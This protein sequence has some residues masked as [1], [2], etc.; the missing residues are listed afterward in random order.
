[1][2]LNSIPNDVFL[3]RRVAAGDEDAFSKLFDDYQ[4]QVSGFVFSIIGDKELTQEIVQDI[5]I[6]V[7]QK[8]EELL[9]I[10]KFDAYLF[11]LSKNYTLNCIRKIQREQQKAT[12]YNTLFPNTGEE[13]SEIDKED[14]LQVIEKAT[15]QL[16]PQQQRVFRLRMEGLKNHEIA[17]QLMISPDSVKKYQQLA[18]KSVTTFVKMHLSYLTL[19]MMMGFMQK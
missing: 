17:A 11:V 18:L 16:P 8:K 6:K 7:W 13:Q 14:Y 1:M 9:E 2:S 10:Q 4:Q 12:E 5:F 15:V 19:W 3:L